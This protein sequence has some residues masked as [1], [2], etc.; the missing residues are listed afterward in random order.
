MGH[1]VY[2]YIKKKQNLKLFMILAKCKS[3]WDVPNSIVI[4]SCFLS[5]SFESF[6]KLGGLIL[7]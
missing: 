1:P 6:E 7:S 3:N 5:N 2:T 4:A